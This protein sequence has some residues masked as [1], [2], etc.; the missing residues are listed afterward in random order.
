M[1][2]ETKATTDELIDRIATDLAPV[3]VARPGRTFAI[4]LAV[5]AVVV[6]AFLALVGG[7][8]DLAERMTEPFF[9]AVVGL[10]A[11]VAAWS[12][13]LA[14]RLA[15]PGRVVSARAGWLL[16]AVPLALAAGVLMLD[17][18]A[19]AWPG[20]A[21]LTTGCLQCAGL[22]AAA[23]VPWLVLLAVV[24]RLAPLNELRVGMFA[25]LSAFLVGAI[26]TELHCASDSSHHLA[27]GHYLPVVLFSAAA[28]V[29]AAAI[30]RVP[31]AAR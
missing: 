8:A 20:L 30:I 29:L 28:C 3:Q 11:V 7:R 24:S 31:A 19:G 4:C 12:A 15:V 22:T 13:S 17:P 1:Q 10:L 18:L 2:G 16:P 5:E 14:I 25:G 21:A 26:V 6:V 9:A 27:L 23:A